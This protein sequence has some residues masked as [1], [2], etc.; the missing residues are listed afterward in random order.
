[1]VSSLHQPMRCIVESV[2]CPGSPE[3][4]EEQ[5]CEALDYDSHESLQKHFQ[6]ISG[7][8]QKKSKWPIREKKKNPTTNQPTPSK[9]PFIFLK[10]SFQ[11][12]KGFA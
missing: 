8:W 6:I 1:M 9:P 7:F 2:F 5:G 10:Y 11:L 12:E 3:Q 4:R